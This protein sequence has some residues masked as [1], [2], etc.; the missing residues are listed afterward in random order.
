M[1]PVAI[2]KNITKNNMEIVET[3]IQ[4]CFI[5]KNNLFR[6]D[7]GY[8]FESFNQEKFSR[9]TGWNGSFVQDN[10]SES[11]FGVV[12]GLH[13]Q[14]GDHA[15]AKLVRVLK[16]EIVDVVLDIRP[17]SPTFGA[18][19]SISLSEDNSTQF[20][21]PRGCAH[22]FS[23]ISP[24]AIFFYKCDNYYHKPSEWGIHPLD[25][26][27]AINWKLEANQVILSE[28]DKNAEYWQSYKSRFL[29][30]L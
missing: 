5:V 17:D 22:G 1:L 9:L 15:Q 16:G 4:G 25:K 12:R 30:K 11:S 13:F 29:Q 24:T 2:T 20:F 10:Q 27:L 19:H 18:S 6:D 8:F 14:T 23:V 26:D 28:K 3:P 21:I 7:R